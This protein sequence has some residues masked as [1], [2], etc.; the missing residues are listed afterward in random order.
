MDLRAIVDAAVDT[1][2]PA[3][4][5]KEIAVDVE[6][7]GRC[8]AGDRRRAA[9]SA[10]AVEP[11]VECGEVHAARR[12]G[13]GRRRARRTAA[14]S[15][16][17]TDTGEG[18]DPSFLPH[19]FEPFRQG[20]AKTMRSGLGLGLAIVKQARRS[21]R[22][23]HHRGERRPRPGRAVHARRAA[24]A[25]RTRRP[26]CAPGAQP[27]PD[28]DHLHVLVAEDDADSAAAVTAILQ[29]HGCETQTAGDAPRSACASPA[30]GR[31]T[32]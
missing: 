7:S 12:H 31:R 27:E 9:S 21:P 6:G 22:R 26:R 24:R 2:R 28:F 30:N 4:A 16:R 23:A 13:H 3:A 11:A 25:R 18:I 8:A 1:I 32:C 19:V 14:R 17:V 5:A 10:G 15:S 20:A 29:L